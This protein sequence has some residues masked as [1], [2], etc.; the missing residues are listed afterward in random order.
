MSGS[1]RGYFAKTSTALPVSLRG[2]LRGRRVAFDDRDAQLRTRCG[3]DGDCV[4]VDSPRCKTKEPGK[5]RAL[6]VGRL[7][8]TLCYLASLAIAW[9]SREIFRLAVFLS[10]TL[11]CAARIRS[12]SAFFIAASAAARSPFLMASSTLRTELRMRVR[13]ALLTMVRRA[14]LR[15]ALRAEV[16][17]AILYVCSVL[18][19]LMIRRRMPPGLS[20]TAA[21]R[22]PLKTETLVVGIAVP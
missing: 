18:V 15:V 14:I 16:V 11:R 22:G 17:L 21:C 1:R 19:R 2:V 12:G 3:E 6:V 9:V 20:C 13:R 5:S 7:T 10:T 8:A 4:S